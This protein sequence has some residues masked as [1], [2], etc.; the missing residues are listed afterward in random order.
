MG[1]DPHG[2]SRGVRLGKAQLA[3]RFL[4]VVTPRAEYTAAMRPEGSRQLSAP[5]A[6]VA[7]C[8]L[9]ASG[10]GGDASRPGG[11]PKGGPGGGPGGGGKPKGPVAVR[12]L[13]ARE[14][15][16]DRVVE[17]SGTLGGA[18]EV[19]I[20]AEVDGRVERVGADLGDTVSKGGVLIQLVGTTLRLQAEQAEAEYLQ[21]LARVGVDDDKLDGVAPNTLASVKRADADLDEARRNARRVV[22]LHG[23]GVVT[24]NDLDTIKT[25]ERIAEAAAQA[26][27]EDARAAIATAKARRAAWGLA[28]KRLADASVTSPVTGVVSERLVSLG[29]LVKAGQ[30]VVRVVVA[31]P[32]K[33]RGDVPE[34]YSLEVKP[35]MPVSI[36][37][38]ALGLGAEGKV[39]R[40]GPAI[41]S[42]S[43]TF[44]VEAVVPN[45]K[46]LLKPGLFARARIVVGNDETVFAIPET[47]VSALAGV[48]KLFVLEDNVAHERK[49]EVLRKRGSDALVTGELKAGDQVIV[50][51]V[52]RLFEGAEVSLDPGA[53]GFPP[54]PSPGGP[55][56]EESP[57]RGAPQP[58]P[59]GDR[60]GAQRTGG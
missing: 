32:L 9:L 48:T 40:V 18:E 56:R 57:P 34:R 58:P 49:V 21:A 1:P 2:L 23:K 28:R 47:A 41:T 37:L 22:E 38:D 17:L 54:P 30:P 14:E 50:T 59:S 43:H 26:A 51:A 6:L 55:P 46:G 42:S 20:S 4:V 15:V 10:C 27:H 3:L 13:E 39:S 45:S 29:E 8:A 16:V 33:L 24:Q 31:D 36:A 5:I 52:A 44:R 25:R 11:G 53:A 60:R 35:D 12:V 7:A 19:T